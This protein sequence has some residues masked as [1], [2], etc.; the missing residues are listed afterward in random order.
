[1]VAPLEVVDVTIARRGQV[2]VD[3][4]DLT[5][6]VGERLAVMGRSGTGKTSLL[7]T[8]ARLTAPH[9]GRIEAPQRVPYVFQEP[10]LMPW[11]TVL[12]NVEFVLPA[13]DRPRALHWLERV[14]LADRAHAFP[15]TFS[16]GMRQRVSIA[17]ALACESPLLL[18]D[19]PFSHL[20]VVTA[21]ALR[22]VLVEHLTTSA[23]AAVWV[24]HDPQE[25][26]LVADRTLLVTGH[27]PWTLLQH[28]AVTDPLSSLTEALQTG[29][30]HEAAQAQPD[31]DPRP[32]DAARR[33]QHH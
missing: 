27:G 6:G 26:L 9:E 15:L 11:R 18:V 17:R 19:E 24:T 16:G 25:A 20:D 3:S 30:P 13:E 28:S 2:L 29:S 7:K 14:G 8:V 31:D 22:Q 4:L 10:R 12:T 32:G 21:R 23:T 33:M 1:M 5:L